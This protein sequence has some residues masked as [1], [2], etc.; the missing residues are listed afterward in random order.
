MKTI[1]SILTLI[2]SFSSIA[3]SAEKMQSNELSKKEVTPIKLVIKKENSQE[4]AFC[5]TPDLGSEEILSI[6]PQQA[7]SSIVFDEHQFKSDTCYQNV[8]KVVVNAKTTE[9]NVSILYKNKYIYVKNATASNFSLMLEI[10]KNKQGEI[11]YFDIINDLGKIKKES[12]VV[13]Y[14]YSI[15]ERFARINKL[16]EK[17]VLSKPAPTRWAGSYSIGITS[18]QYTQINTNYSSI[19]TTIKGGLRYRLA[20]KWTLKGS[21]FFNLFPIT[22]NNPDAFRVLGLNFLAGYSLPNLGSWSFS[23]NGGGYYLTSFIN[24]NKFGFTNI[25]GPEALLSARNNLSAKNAID[26]YLKF[27][28]LSTGRGIARFSNNEIAAGTGYSFPY[29]SHIM[30]VNL[31]LSKLALPLLYNNVEL[32]TYSLSIGM[33]L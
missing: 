20:D 8:N 18:L 12:F 14:K 33:S 30:S 6:E 25:Y 21:A 28:L 16:S 22:K 13:R 31:D 24:N 4:S 5:S 11:F 26:L 2:F 27:A 7:N 29:G 3:F 15:T 23:A 32:K 10:P 17:V 9:A 19:S 1:I